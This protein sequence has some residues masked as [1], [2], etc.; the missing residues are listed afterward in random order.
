[1]SFSKLNLSTELTAILAGQ[2]DS[3]TDVQMRAIPALQAGSD[4]IAIAQTG[5]G[6]TLAYGL[7]MIDSLKPS[8]SQSQSQ[9]LILV[10]TRELAAQV[11]QALECY[12][13]ALG[14]SSVV[15]CG[16]VE[17]SVQVEQL[18]TSPELIIA[19]P[20]RLLDLLNEKELDASQL[21]HVVLDEADRLLDLG[22]W[23]DIQQILQHLP[24]KRQMVMFSA[25]WPDEL[26]KKANTL[27]NTPVQINVDPVNSV[28]KKIEEKLYLV[29]K[30]AKANVLIQ[31]VKLHQWQQVLVF[32]SARDNADALAK[33]LNKAGITTAA[34][35]GNKPQAEREQTLEDFKQKSIQVLISTDLLARG[36]HVESLPVVVNVDLPSHPEVY[37]HRVGRTAR[38]GENGLAVSLVSH[39]ETDYL[40]AIRH[41]TE[42]ELPLEELAEFPVTD[43]PATGQSKRPKRDKQANRRTNSKSSIK[44]FKSRGK[45]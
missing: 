7:P 2:F 15:L 4:V 24:K 12:L 3:P 42:R 13:S 31:Q 20:G 35:H 23:P 37:V 44:Q 8:L 40:Q 34:L 5:S 10:P 11:A 9:S 18:R 22:F 41:L 26:D 17:K 16:G 43:K 28:V 27:L 1:M 14:L 45:R 29:N 19:T 39:G 32:I 30:G 38:A 33:K 36:I 25:T 6:K 21:S